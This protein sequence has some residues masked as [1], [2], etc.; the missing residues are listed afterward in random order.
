MSAERVLVV[1]LAVT[2]TLAAGLA[3]QVGGAVRLPPRRLALVIAANVIALPLLTYAGLRLAAVDAGAGLMLAAAA[4]GGSTGPLLAVLGR[5]DAAIAAVAFV[6]LTLVGMV[7][8]IGATIALDAAGLGAIVRAS[9][10]VTASSVGP[11]LIGLAARRRWPARAARWQPWLARV[12]LVLLVA[13]I[14]LL[15][16][17]HGE[18]ARAV[19]VAVGAIVTVVALAI[20]LVVDGRAARV[21]V[22]QVSAVRNLTLV[23][24]VLAVIGAA[25]AETMAALAF[26]LAM[27]VVTLGAAVAWR[28]ATTRR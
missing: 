24:L 10:V 14:V 16:V 23:L 1:A 3:A 27:Y 25:P 2:S 28:S 9:L 13:T 12:S 20:G 19:D 18:S 21:A 7:A 4:P 11:L 8:A 15:A 6:A 5:G 22:A 26:G 17:R